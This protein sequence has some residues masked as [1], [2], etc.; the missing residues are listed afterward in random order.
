MWTLFIYLFLCK[1]KVSLRWVYEQGVSVIV[2]S[3]NKERMKH[4]LDIFGWKLS[5]EDL[6][7]IQQI[8]QYR[9]NRAEIFISEDGLFKTVEEL[10]DGEI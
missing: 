10:W 2:K 1:L 4:N 8:P 6:Q 3:F 9:G 5:A 7:K